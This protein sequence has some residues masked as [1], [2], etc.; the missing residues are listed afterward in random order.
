MMNKCSS[1]K[2]NHHQLTSSKPNNLSKVRKLLKSA[3]TK[4]ILNNSFN[5][6]NLISINNNFSFSC[7]DINNYNNLN[8]SSVHLI[9][10]LFDL[11]KNLFNVILSKAIKSIGKI[12]FVLN[13]KK[14]LVIL[15][16]CK[17]LKIL[18]LNINQTR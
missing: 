15:I 2:Q 13:R 10:F 11:I 6:K 8:N 7:I 16:K 4:S 5:D 3:T 18:N 14:N 12:C 1:I 9:F 17:C